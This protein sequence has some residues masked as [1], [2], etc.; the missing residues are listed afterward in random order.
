M[1]LHLSRL[2]DFTARLIVRRS[3]EPE[4]GLGEIGV[5]TEVR[6]GVCVY[7][8]RGCPVFLCSCKIPYFLQKG[9]NQ[10]FNGV[11]SI[12][13]LPFKI[14]NKELFCVLMQSEAL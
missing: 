1:K 12:L 8:E 3:C 6:G 2:L 14:N 4:T 7:G 11:K 5:L 9:K 13:A 10:I